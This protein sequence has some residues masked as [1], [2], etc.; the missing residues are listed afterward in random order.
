MIEQFYSKYL[1]NPNKRYHSN[2]SEFVN[3]GNEEVS[4]IA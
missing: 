3:N 2:Q 4:Y 1:W